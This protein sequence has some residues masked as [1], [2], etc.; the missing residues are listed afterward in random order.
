MYAFLVYD[1]LHRHR[2]RVF[3]VRWIMGLFSNS[4]TTDRAATVGVLLVVC[5]VFDLIVAGVVSEEYKHAPFGEAYWDALIASAGIFFSYHHWSAVLSF[6]ALLIFYQLE[7]EDL[8]NSKD[9][10][11]YIGGVLVAGLVLTFS[12]YVWRVYRPEELTYKA[13]SSRATR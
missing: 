11:A 7:Q 1:E 10:S 6:F 4:D 5:A 3:W 8:D 2:G 13:L 9:F 12:N